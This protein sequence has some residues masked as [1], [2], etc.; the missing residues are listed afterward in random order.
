MFL[1][2]DTECSN[3]LN[4]SRGKIFETDY[5]T[6]RRRFIGKNYHVYSNHARQASSDAL[7]LS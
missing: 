6:F 2:F 4:I 5:I 1:V 7:L 3:G